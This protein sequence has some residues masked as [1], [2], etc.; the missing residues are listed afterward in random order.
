MNLPGLPPPEPLE[1]EPTL[2][3]VVR[4]CFACPGC[5]AVGKSEDPRLIQ[6]LDG[7]GHIDTTCKCGKLLRVRRRLVT[8]ANQLPNREARRAIKVR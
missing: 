2:E 5:G 3:R 4:A 8:L 7:F 1:V 6:H